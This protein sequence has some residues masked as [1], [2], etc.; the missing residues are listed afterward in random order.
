MECRISSLVC[1]L[2]FKLLAVYWKKLLPVYCSSH[3]TTTNP[4]SHHPSYIVLYWLTLSYIVLHCFTLSY[5][6]LHCPSLSYNVYCSSHHT[7]PT[8]SSHHCSFFWELFSN[9]K[10]LGVSDL[11]VA[12]TIQ[13]S[14][15]W[16][17]LLYYSHLGFG[18]TVHCGAIWMLNCVFMAEICSSGISGCLKFFILTFG[19][20][21]N[22]WR[23][24]WRI[25]LFYPFQ[26]IC[27]QWS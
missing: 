2:F 21:N 17:C 3:R 16:Q 12:M 10:E 19:K 6:V 1:C 4:S 15:Y 18:I 9:I 22:I 27:H 14:F 11:I 13:M 8:P 7:T 25:L 24:G 26:R 23:T 20:Y 5:L